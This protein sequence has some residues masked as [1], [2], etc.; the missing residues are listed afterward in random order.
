M[1]MTVGQWLFAIGLGSV[2][3]AA[4][5]ALFHCLNAERSEPPFYGW[6]PTCGNCPRYIDA[7]TRGH[8]IKRL[9]GC[10]EV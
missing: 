4:I 1:T 9:T 3:G 10:S 8:C 6:S 2:L 5:C 7:V